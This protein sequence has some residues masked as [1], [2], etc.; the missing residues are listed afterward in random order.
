MAMTKAER[1]ELQEA[2]DA[3]ALVRAMHFPDYPVPQPMTLDEILASLEPGGLRHGSPQMVA[4]GWNIARGEAIK[5]C[6]NGYNSGWGDTTSSQ[7]MGVLYRSPLDAWRAHRHAETTKAAKHLAEIDA[8]IAAQD[9][10]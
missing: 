2:R 5:V 1:A 4:F 9:G 6:S 8:A 7:G 3:L 10:G